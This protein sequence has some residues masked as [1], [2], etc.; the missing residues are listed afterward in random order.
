MSKPLRRRTGQVWRKGGGSA[1]SVSPGT[2]RVEVPRPGQG[3]RVRTEMKVSTAVLVVGIFSSGS[4]GPGWEA[5]SNC[6]T[7]PAAVDQIDSV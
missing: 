6:E 3:R 7:Q 2:T 4:P 1:L 5:S